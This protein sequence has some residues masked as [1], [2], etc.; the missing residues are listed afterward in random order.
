M[1]IVQFWLID[2][3]IRSN[4]SYELTADEDYVYEEFDSDP[5][6]VPDPPSIALHS[7][8]ESLPIEDDDQMRN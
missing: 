3:F 6:R 5:V 2:S 8:T 1:N 4:R 7:S